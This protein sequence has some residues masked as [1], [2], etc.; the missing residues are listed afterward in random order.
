MALQF[1][2]LTMF[3]KAVLPWIVSGGSILLVVLYVVYQRFFHPLA[4]IAG[5]SWASLTRLWMAKHSWD[6][7]EPFPV[8][9]K[10][11]TC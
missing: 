4:S 2:D 5:P 1:S 7:K 8:V 3:S 10:C 11:N 6:G 9:A